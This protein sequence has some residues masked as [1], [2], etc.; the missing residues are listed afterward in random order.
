M[1]YACKINQ[2]LA[3]RGGD[4]SAKMVPGRWQGPL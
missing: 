1:A 2:Y 3:G 4:K